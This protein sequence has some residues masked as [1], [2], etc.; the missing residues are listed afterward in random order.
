MMFEYKGLKIR[1]YGHDTFS[2]ESDVRIFFDPYKLSKQ[3][4]ADLILISHDHFDHLSLEDL[5]KISTTKTTIVA[6]KECVNKITGIAFKEKMGI[7]PGE[8]K[9][10][11]GIRIRAISAYNIDKINHDTKKPFHPKE[12]NKIGFLVNINGIVIYHTGD[13]DLIPEMFN[14]RPD[15]LLIPVSGTYVMTNKEAAKATEIIKPKIAIPMHYGTIVG[16]ERDATE[17]KNLVKSCE[18]QILTKE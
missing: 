14:L 17:F 2:I 16:T 11:N 6:A 13:S 12:D 1:W 4:E 10:V 8:E 18:V 15:I 7:A 5:Q 3:S 9:T